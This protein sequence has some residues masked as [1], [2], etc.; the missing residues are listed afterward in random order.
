MFEKVG[1]E[2]W[3]GR[4]L[5]NWLNYETKFTTRNGKKITLSMIY[6]LLKEPFYYGEFEYPVGSKTMYKGLH[7]PLITKELFNQ[8]QAKLTV[9]PKRHPGTNDYEFTRLLVCGNCGSGVTAEEKF[10][11]IKNGNTHRYVYYHCCR[12]KNRNCRQGSI[13]E[14][15]LLRQ[16]LQI[17]DKIDLDEAGIKEKIEEEIIRYRKFMGL[18]LGQQIELEQRSIQT[19]IR[20]YAKYLINEGSKEEKRMLLSCLRSKLE[21]K[22]KIIYLKFEGK[23]KI[24]TKTIENKNL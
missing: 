16:L 23:N 7:E 11:K 8:V 17:I 13:R 20:N 19:D 18:V 4:D 12:S 1:Y 3:S 24:N 6:R 22:D 9:A 2:Y 15:E 10:K 14:E 21:L 5:L